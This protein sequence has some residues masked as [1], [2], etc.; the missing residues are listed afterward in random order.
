MSPFTSLNL[1][2]PLQKE[3]L[4][5]TYGSVTHTAG[6]ILPFFHS[7]GNVARHRADRLCDLSPPSVQKMWLS[8]LQWSMMAVMCPL[9]S[10]VS[11]DQI[12]RGHT[13]FLSH[14]LQP[15]W[16]AL[17]KLDKETRWRGPRSLVN[18]GEA[19]CL[20]SQSVELLHF[21]GPWSLTLSKAGIFHRTARSQRK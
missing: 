18:Y 20:L 6:F 21:W 2:S 7:N 5:L 16:D 14:W 11:W 4:V 10:L 3:E 9:P 1:F 17:S 8:S 12:R 13:V 15:R 19:S